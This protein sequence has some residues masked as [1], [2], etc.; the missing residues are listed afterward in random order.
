[1]ETINRTT[2]KLDAAGQSPGRLATEIAHILQGKNR[3]DYKPNIDMGDLVEVINA[4]DMKITGKKMAQ[5]I[6]YRHSGHPGGLK[7]TVLKD[8]FAKDPA[9][10]LRRAVLRMLPKNKLQTQR[11]LRLTINNAK[12]TN[13]AK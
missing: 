11:I 9:E 7:E 1:M 5:K 8:L 2:H 6:Y 10:V 3:P 13:E 4:K 12:A